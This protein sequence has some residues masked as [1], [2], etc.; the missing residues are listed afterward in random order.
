MS[1]TD[2]L[3]TLYFCVLRVNPSCPGMPERDRFIMSKGH[4]SAS[5]YSTLAR[6]G[7]FPERDLWTFMQPGSA[8]SGHPHNGIVPG[9]E[10]STGPL[11]HGMPIAVGAALSAKLDG[12][13]WRVFVLT[14]DGELEEGT[15]W[16][17]AMTAAHYQLDNLVLIVDRNRFQQGAE[18]EHTTRL[19]PLADKWRAFGWAVRETDGHDYAALRDVL[20]D[21]PFDPGRPSCLIAHTHKGQGVSFMRDQVGWHHRIPT[22]DE[23]ERALHELDGAER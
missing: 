2:I 23:L 4:A 20:G 7:F 3:V 16:E 13:S 5:F 14:G 1:A 12:A 8:L 9:V 19:E 18:T 22:D 21:V 11:G 17:A 10:A 6:A 15:N